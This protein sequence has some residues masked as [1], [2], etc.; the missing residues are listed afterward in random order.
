MNYPKQ[1]NKMKE[2]RIMKKITFGRVLAGIA[3]VCLCMITGT[4]VISEYKRYQPYEERAEWY[5]SDC[6]AIYYNKGGAEIKNMVTGKTTIKGIDWMIAADLHPDTLVVFSKKQRRGYFNRYTG[7]IVVPEQYTHAWIFSED[8]AAVVANDKVGFINRK[9][10]TVIDFRFP[11]MKDNRKN[12]NFVFHDGCCSM[13]DE[14]GKCGMINKKGEWVLEP[15]YDKIHTPVHGKRIFEEDGKWGVLDDSLRVAI[16]AEY[17][18]IVL[19]P[20]YAIV[21][22]PDEVRQQIAYTGEML[23]PLL[24]YAVSRLDYGTGTYRED[25]SEILA[26]T[27]IYRYR[28]GNK[29]GL[30]DVNGKIITLPLYYN[31]DVVTKNLFNCTLEDLYSDILLNEKGEAVQT[32]N[33]D[34][35]NK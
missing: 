35:Q 1:N 4:I 24:Y 18:Y 11:Y 2:E 10:E 21:E 25:G 16:P 27:G 28:I 19:T 23:N 26:S 9:G 17:T 8:V 6:K 14:T 12:V 31:I 34:M 22:R 30:M 15:R 13:Y 5:S 32:S 33:E 29:Y 3:V 20:D 7:D